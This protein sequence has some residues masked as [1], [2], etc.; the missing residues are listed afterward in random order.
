MNKL[1][2]SLSLFS[3]FVSPAYS[4]SY[5]DGENFKLPF[6]VV[7]NK[8]EQRIEDTVE[9]K[10][11]SIQ[12]NTTEYIL[13]QNFGCVI[14]MSNNDECL[15]HNKHLQKNIID[16]MEERKSIVLKMNAMKSIFECKIDYNDFPFIDIFDEKLFDLNTQFLNIKKLIKNKITS[17]EQQNKNYYY[18]AVNFSES[19][20][21]EEAIITLKKITKDYSKYA[22]VI[23][24]IS[25]NKQKL[26]NQIAYEN[27]M[28]RGINA[29]NNFARRLEQYFL[30]KGMDTS[31]TANGEYNQSLYINYIFAGR[32]LAN[33]FRKSEMCQLVKRFGFTEIVFDSDYTDDLWTITFK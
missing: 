7:F 22:K 5:L 21:F 4:Q 1:L 13:L 29:R 8:D 3:F 2:M 20:R 25:F 27:R 28:N 30:D 24:Y 31:I 16:L 12:R 10:E 11:L 33:T 17:L 15:I 6:Q 9:W 18:I 32:V 23:K 19:R 14:S 26:S